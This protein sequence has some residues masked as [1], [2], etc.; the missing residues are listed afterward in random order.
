M[1]ALDTPAAGNAAPALSKSGLSSLQRGVILTGVVIQFLFIHGLVWQRLSDLDASIL[2]SYA[3]IPLWV[4]GAL[5]L[6]R[7]LELRHFF[8]AT[9][10]ITLLKFL[11]TASILILV[12]IAGGSPRAPEG[13]SLDLP[14]ASTPAA[15]MVPVAT[16]PLAPPSII[17]AERRGSLAGLVR[18]AGGRPVTGALVW[19]SSGLERY[20]FAPRTDTLELENDGAGFKPV[21]A[22]LQL[23]QPLSLRARDLHLHTLAGELEG[24]Q[25]FNLPVLASGAPTLERLPRDQPLGEIAVWCTVAGA[26]GVESASRLV[27]LAHPFFTTTDAAGRFEITDVPAGD[28]AISAIAGVAARGG[29]NVTLPATQRV[30]VQIDLP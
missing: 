30:E 11:I 6:A 26:T 23:G 25:V 10:E 19:V 12:L 18:D 3:T 16:P 29:K 4:G 27:V 22:A 14:I 15:S 7:R 13:R 8:L 1:T 2:W 5:L 20:D 24:R 28:L 9:L 17:P 21:V